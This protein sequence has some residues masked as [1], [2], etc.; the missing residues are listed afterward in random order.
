MTSIQVHMRPSD[1]IKNAVVKMDAVM[2]ELQ[3]HR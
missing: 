1:V 2:K 3:V